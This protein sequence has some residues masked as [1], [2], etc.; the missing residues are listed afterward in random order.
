MLLKR[1]LN[2]PHAVDYCRSDVELVSSVETSQSGYQLIK[3]IKQESTLY[4]MS[5]LSG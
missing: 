1:Q 4:Q 5:A 2:Q 3:Q